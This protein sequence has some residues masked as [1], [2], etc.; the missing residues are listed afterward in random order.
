MALLHMVTHIMSA[1]LAQHHSDRNARKAEWFVEREA[2]NN[3]VG[4]LW[5]QI[6]GSGPRVGVG[7]RFIMGQVY[8]RDFSPSGLI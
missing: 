8:A 5:T 6:A 3:T 1:A 7:D 4:A 2:G